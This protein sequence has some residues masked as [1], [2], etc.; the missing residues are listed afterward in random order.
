MPKTEAYYTHRR[1]GKQKL[2]QYTNDFLVSE[3][4]ADIF[5]ISRNT[6]RRWD[7]AG[8]LKPIKIGRRKLYRR[9]EIKQLLEAE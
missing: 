7:K 9:E 6:I 3:E 1:G 5:R 2:E 4:V 8:K